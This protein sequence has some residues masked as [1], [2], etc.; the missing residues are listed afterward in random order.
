MADGE[1]YR[2]VNKKELINYARELLDLTN[3]T[4]LVSNY[5]NEIEFASRTI[6]NTEVKLYP[7]TGTFINNNR[8]FKSARPYDEHEI[9]AQIKYCIKYHINEKI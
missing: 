2:G 5:G 9:K 7:T 1:G 3:T 4:Y 6:L 8:T